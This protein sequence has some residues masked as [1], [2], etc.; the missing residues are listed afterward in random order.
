MIEVI[1]N[2]L[3]EE[4]FTT[5]HDAM[6]SFHFPWFYN[7]DKIYDG[8][9]DFQFTHTFYNYN[10]PQSREYDDLIEPIIQ[11]LGGDR[12]SLLRVKA[13]LTTPKTQPRGTGLHVDFHDCTTCILYITESDGP[14]RFESGETIECKPNRLVV[15][16]SNLY[17]E[18]VHHTTSG[19][20]IVINFN[21][22][23][24]KDGLPGTGGM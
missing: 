11:K 9:G 19:P 17:H 24:L 7:N 10:R 1:E 8:D 3:E 20:R 16:D 2:F 4:N 13:N 18:A 5:L 23:R 12:I 15:F 6:T 21:F 14:T 22:F